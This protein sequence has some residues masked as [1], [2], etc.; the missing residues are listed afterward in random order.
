VRHDYQ[1][2]VSLEMARR[3]AALV[4]ARPELIEHARAN[5]A[6]WSV[7]N[8]DAPGLLRCYQEWEDILTRP[9]SEVVAALTGT[10]DASRRLRQSSP[11]TGVLPPEEVRQIKD[12]LRDDPRAA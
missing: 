1:D 9:L 2:R 8:K 10:S 5:L 6:R 7:Q 4:A 3:V 11:F 12:R